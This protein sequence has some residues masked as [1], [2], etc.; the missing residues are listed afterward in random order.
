MVVDVPV[1]RVYDR[2]LINTVKHHWERLVSTIARPTNRVEVVVDF[3]L[4]PD[5]HISSVR[6]ARSTADE[7]AALT[8]Q[9][10]VVESAPFAVWPQK[11]RQAVTNDWRDVRFTFSLL[12]RICGLTP[13]LEAGPTCDTKLFP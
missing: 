11:I 4:H 8:C 3:K 1:F 5:G 2:K 6:V 7:K 13:A 10:S 12:S 9:R